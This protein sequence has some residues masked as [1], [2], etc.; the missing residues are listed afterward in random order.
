MFVKEFEIDGLKIK[1]TRGSGENPSHAIETNFFK[2][3]GGEAY[4]GNNHEAVAM[5]DGMAGIFDSLLLAM[6]SAGYF[7]FG[8][9]EQ[10]F[11]FEE[12]I[13]TI[14]DALGNHQ[15]LDELDTE[16]VLEKGYF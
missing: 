1:F 11:R 9:I 7:E 16:E 5:I 3:S 6:F 13:Q 15:G 4:M 12:T 2:W 8:N 10:R 14:I